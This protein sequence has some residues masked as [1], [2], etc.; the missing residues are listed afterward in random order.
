M[1]SQSVSDS[2]SSDENS[3]FTNPPQKPH[4]ATSLNSQGQGLGQGQGGTQPKE[5]KLWSLANAQMKILGKCDQSYESFSWDVQLGKTLDQILV[6]TPP[7]RIGLSVVV[8][9]VI[10]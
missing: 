9:G 8:G 1:A 7:L 6:P 10:S 5:D 3:D 4:V 2:S